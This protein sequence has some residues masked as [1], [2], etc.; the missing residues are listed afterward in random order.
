VTQLRLSF[1]RFVALC[2]SMTLLLCASLPPRA[3][4][5]AVPYA[6]SFAKSKDEVDN[7]LNEL[8]AYA[9]QK[10][11]AVEGFVAAGD[12]PLNRFERA[13]Y[14][15]S[16]DLLPASP[17]GTPDGTIVRLTAK[18]TA[19]YADPD[20]SRSGYQV[21][22]SNGRLELDL[23]DRLTE[24]VDGK[25]PTSLLHSEVQAPKPKLDLSTGLPGASL[26]S[27]PNKAGG[28]ATPADAP[29]GTD[30]MSALRAKREAEERRAQQLNAELQTLQEV[31]RNQAHPLN[32]VVV[33]KNGTAVLAR[34]VEGSRVLFSAAAGDE[35]EFLDNQGDWIHV[36]ISGASRGYLR[37]SSLELPEF[38]AARLKPPNGEAASE[39]PAPFGLVREETSTFPGGWPVLRGKP[40]KICTVQPVSQDPRETGAAA[41]LNFAASLFRKFSADSA[42]AT[43][44]LDGIVVIFDSADG[45]LIAAT[46]STAQ[47][48]AAGS[49]SPENFWKQCYADPPEAFRQQ[50]KP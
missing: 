19:W 38:I 12:Q 50:S 41:K 29:S 33:K 15:F 18:I 35:F 20:P 8:Q 16:I 21:L 47:Q 34:A 28:G 49:L 10:L 4:A 1:P 30:E 14:Q 48:L 3:N 13:F 23:L 11:P 27:N 45:G 37:R 5:Q 24:K 6:R 9:G 22:S 2:S 40:V 39:K 32:L 7:A 17:S 42:A 26:F 25:S 46:L 44:P 36:Q 31:H 43:P